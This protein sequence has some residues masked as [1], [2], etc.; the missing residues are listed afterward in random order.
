MFAFG[1]LDLPRYQ[2]PLSGVRLMNNYDLGHRRRLE[3]QGVGDSNPGIVEHF[4][5]LFVIG[6]DA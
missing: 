6:G 2:H 4:K 5:C 1:Q 3:K